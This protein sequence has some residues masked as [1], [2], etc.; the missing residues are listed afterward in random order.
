LT[1]CNSSS[2]TVPK[3]GSSSSPSLLSQ[4]IKHVFVLVQENH[5][6]DNYFGLYPGSGG[7][8]IENLGTATAKAVDCVP[9]PQTGSCQLPF[10]ISANPSS[11]NYVADAPDIAGG[12]NSRYGQEASIDKGAMDGFL[13]DD[14]GSGAPLIGPASTPAQIE[15]HNVALSIMSVYDCD[16]VPYEW[17]YAKNFALFDH[18]FQAD[19]GPSTPGNIQ[20]F[21]GQVGQTEAAAQKGMLSVYSGGSN[22]DGV[23]ITNDDNPP[24]AVPGFIPPYSPSG[25]AGDPS[26]F[27]SYAT[28]PV[29]LNPS[30]DN[31]AYTAGI[32]GFIPDDMR[33]EATTGRSSVPWA[34]YEEGLYTPNGGLVSHH[35]APMYFDYINHINSPFATTSSLRDNTAANGL[36]ADIKAGTLPSSGVFWVKG[37]NS[38]QYGLHPADPVFGTKYFVGD[39]DHPGSTSGGNSDHQVA[40]AYL[41]EVINAIANS[42]YWKDSVIIVTWDD[43]GGLYD[44][45]APPSYG[46]ACPNDAG[47]P[48]GGTCGNGVR[49]PLLV[50]SPFSKTGAVVQDVSD[51]GSV[52]KFIEAVF[53]LPTLASLPDEAQGVAAGL[54]PADANPATS[55]I[56]DALDPNKLNGTTAPNPASLATIPAPSVPP[57]MSC[58]TLG[59]T[60]LASPAS[61]PS[62]FHTA[63]S[64]LHAALTGS[65][66]AYSIR[67]AIDTDD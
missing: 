58:A 57:S 2:T 36:I 6:F 66:P 62:G 64:Y 53:G 9:D 3:P 43:S 52:S 38:N 47:S 32:T 20:L 50:I 19:T 28:M 31:V 51:A 34:W 21:A 30:E 14:E 49:V 41:A 4:K 22:S 54:P 5:T 16:T 10:L 37:G 56:T 55:N 24:P 40:E 29:L 15:A 60:P 63:G 12:D 65:A 7:Q 44:H 8:A 45:L 67:P 23:P 1:S 18:Y 59:I 17:Y 48:V 33:R 27:Q 26:T 11:P 35:A 39:D 61:V 13:A 25:Q 46:N 42:N